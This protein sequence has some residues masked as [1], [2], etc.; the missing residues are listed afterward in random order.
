MVALSAA[1]TPLKCDIATHFFSFQPTS[2]GGNWIAP[3]ARIAGL[4]AAI[5]SLRRDSFLSVREI[6]CRTQGGT[7]TQIDYLLELT[8]AASRR[9]V[10]KARGTLT[11]GV[12]L[13]DAGERLGRDVVRRLLQDGV[14]AACKVS[15]AGPIQATPSAHVAARTMP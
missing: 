12:S 3:D 8:D 14:L 1:A 4:R 2:I 7:L 15:A 13:S 11:R 10:W 6:V 5:S 9:S